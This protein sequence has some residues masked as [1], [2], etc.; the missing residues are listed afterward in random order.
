MKFYCDSFFF[1][2][3]KLFI[4]HII[5]KK[6]ITICLTYTSYKWKLLNDFNLKNSTVLSLDQFLF[7]PFLYLCKLKINRYID[8]GF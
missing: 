4:V 2:S 8:W 1:N 7:Q 6:K 5:F 3:L